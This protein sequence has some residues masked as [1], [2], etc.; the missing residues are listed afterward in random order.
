MKFNELCGRRLQTTRNNIQ[1]KNRHEGDHASRPW[2]YPK[3]YS[4]VSDAEQ[5]RI[6]SHKWRR[7]HEY[8]RAIQLIFEMSS[9]PTCVCWMVRTFQKFMTLVPIHSSLKIEQ[10]TRVIFHRR[11]WGINSLLYN[12]LVTTHQLWHPVISARRYE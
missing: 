9:G 4:Y 12:A 3:R 6:G 5:N 7:D 8:L 2:Q 11:Y 1:L 10:R